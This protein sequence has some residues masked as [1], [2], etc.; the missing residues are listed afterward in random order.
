[1]TR[2]TIGAGLAL[3]ALVLLLATAGPAPAQTA[4]PEGSPFVG[5]CY[6]V[7]ILAK[8]DQVAKPANRQAHINGYDA[9]EDMR[10]FNRLGKPTDFSG[11]GLFVSIDPQGWRI[12]VPLTNGI[13]CPMIFFGVGPKLH[14]LIIAQIARGAI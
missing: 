8:A 7:D 9:R 2:W 14:E 12:M 11:D 3:A 10:I 5:G 13:G 4:S 1:M 6:P